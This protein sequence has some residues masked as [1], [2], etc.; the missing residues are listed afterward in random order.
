MQRSLWTLAFLLATQL[1]LAA[2]GQTKV[3]DK[4][5]AGVSE[6]IAA[7]VSS[8]GQQVSIGNA[9]V[10]TLWLAKDL[11]AKAGFQPSLN[12]KY[13]FTPGQLVGVIEVQQKSGFT[14]FRGQ[15]V[16]AGV[17]TL[18][19]GQQPV[20]GNHVGTS[21]LYD[22]LLAIPA[23]TDSDPAPIKAFED[24]TKKSAATAGANHPAIYSLLPAEAGAKSGTL[25]HDAGKDHWI[26]TIVGQSSGK[27]LPLKVIVVG[28][29]EA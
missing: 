6:K 21:E 7:A 13:P 1:G 23:K 15:D 10:C 5:P 4:P 11:P 26:L 24:L 16:A 18:R 9:P 12:V 14:D 28:K 20:D 2:D 17:Y 3:V 22:F 8:A 27:P 19:Y 25:E 29:S